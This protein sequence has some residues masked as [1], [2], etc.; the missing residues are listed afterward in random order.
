ML[1]RSC[2]GTPIVG[3]LAGRV[4]TCGDTHEWI[5]VAT[6]NCLDFRSG[7]GPGPYVTDCNRG[8]YQ[9]RAFSLDVRP[10]A[11]RQG[12]TGLCLVAR[13]GQAVMKG[14]L[15]DDPAALW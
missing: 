10:T 3:E 9:A 6:G 11:M 2:A 4:G 15:A 5:S 8:V 12:E 1:W 14:C 7:Y 13:N